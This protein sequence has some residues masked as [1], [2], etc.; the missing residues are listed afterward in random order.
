MKERFASEEAW[1]IWNGETTKATR[2][3]LPQD[4]HRKARMAL[5]RVVLATQPGDLAHRGDFKMLRGHLRGVY[6][7]RIDG[8][9]RVR[10]EWEHGRAVR[11]RCG[12]FHDEDE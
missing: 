8:G 1:L 7:F 10:F 12:E 6:Q 9:Y 3:V 11:I 4:L 5:E 2:R